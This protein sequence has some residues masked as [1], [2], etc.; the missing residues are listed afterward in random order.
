MTAL[1]GASGAAHL[2]YTAAG[3]C[4]CCL[5]SGLATADPAR[6]TTA[7][8]FISSVYPHT[9]ATLATLGDGTV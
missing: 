6:H 9:A 1:L 3:C 2:L 5:D 7:A 8:V 4:L